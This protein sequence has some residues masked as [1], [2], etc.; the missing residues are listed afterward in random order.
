[1]FV[2]YS[3][4]TVCDPAKPESKYCFLSPPNNR[5]LRRLR[6]VLKRR[7]ARLRRTILRDKKSAPVK[8]GALISWKLEACR[9]GKAGYPH[10]QS[11]VAIDK[12]YN[13][14]SE[15]SNYIIKSRITKLS[16]LPC[17][18]KIP[19]FFKNAKNIKTPN[20]KT[21]T[22]IYSHITLLNNLFSSQTC[23]SPTIM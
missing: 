23:E 13:I 5:S 8:S 3:L 2:F 20:I 19:H 10:C 12:S 17:S 1:M 18:R 4:E 11:S 7:R 21:P 9:A 6:I 16:P 22:Q 15:V 14:V